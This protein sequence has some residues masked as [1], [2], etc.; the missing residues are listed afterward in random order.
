MDRIK[1]LI[2]RLN[3]MHEQ[4][5]DVA[6]LK[7][8]AQL[9]L[10]EIQQQEIKSKTRQ[11][12]GKVSVVMPAGHAAYMPAEEPAQVVEKVPE[13]HVVPEV[14]AEEFVPVSKKEKVKAS[15]RSKELHEVLGTTSESLNDK[16]KEKK[17]ELAEVL[18]DTP[19]K[20]LKKAISLNERFIFIAELFQNNESMFDRSVKT[21][22]SFNILSEAMF[23]LERELKVKLEWEDKSEAALHF[24]SLVKRRYS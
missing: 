20:D 6:H 8:T 11:N 22:N 5:A 9:L 21:L 24:I 13:M 17:T 14:S 23:W 12:S 7:M 2:D 19:I 18:T 10:A 4:G 15:D 1:A 3:E 16:L